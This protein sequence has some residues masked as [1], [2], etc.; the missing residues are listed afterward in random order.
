MKIFFCLRCYTFVNQNY[1]RQSKFLNN[2]ATI[3][4][5]EPCTIE[6]SALY[7]LVF[8]PPCYKIVYCG[9]DGYDVKNGN[10]LYF[11]EK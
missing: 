9:M 8:K 2:T 10:F 11:I 6:I 1:A 4:Y 7:L 5:N 3:K